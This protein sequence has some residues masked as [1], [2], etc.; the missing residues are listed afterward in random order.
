MSSKTPAN[1]GAFARGIANGVA[2]T[3]LTG[4]GNYKGFAFDTPATQAAFVSDR[5]DCEATAPRYKLY[6]WS[7]TPTRRASCRCPPTARRSNGRQRQRPARV[8][9][10]R[11]APLF[12]HRAA[13]RAPSPT[14]PP[15]LIKV[16]IWNYKDPEMQPMQ[17]VRADRSEADLSAR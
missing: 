11:R 8:F 17:K 15:D 1:D 16:D 14:M 6:Q 9:E 2:K 7:T 5:D 10:G 4:P 13:A 3:L 12:R